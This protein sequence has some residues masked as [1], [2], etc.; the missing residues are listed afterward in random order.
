MIRCQRSIFEEP[1]LSR[2]AIERRQIMGEN[3][4]TPSSVPFSRIHS[5]RVDLS[6]PWQRI[7]RTADSL[8]LVV[9]RAGTLDTGSID[10]AT[11]LTLITT[12]IKQESRSPISSQ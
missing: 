11:M 7:I 4:D 12:V 10:L 3:T 9:V 5:K 1:V 2:L 6:I 8:D